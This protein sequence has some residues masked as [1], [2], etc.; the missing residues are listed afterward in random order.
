MG[1]SMTAAGTRLQHR[2]RDEAVSIGLMI[3]DHDGASVGIGTREEL[4]ALIAEGVLPDDTVIRA[5]AP[6]DF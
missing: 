1:R 3:A 4:G 5:P 6:A 2:Y